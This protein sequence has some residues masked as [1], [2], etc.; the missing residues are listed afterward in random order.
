VCDIATVQM[1]S[2]RPLATEAWVR[3]QGS[4][5]EICDDE[6]EFGHIYP[7]VLHSYPVS[8]IP[9]MLHT[10]SFI[11]ERCYITVV[12]TAS[13]SDTLKRSNMKIFPNCIEV[14]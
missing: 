5:Y 11:Y 9:L 4:A 10:H 1:V 2:H 6:V 8:I 12:I 13:L 7:H 14:L 3:S